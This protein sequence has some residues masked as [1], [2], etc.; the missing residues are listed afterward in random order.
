[1]VLELASAINIFVSYITCMDFDIFCMHNKHIPIYMYIWSLC[2]IHT[3]SNLICLCLPDMPLHINQYAFAVLTGT[4][5][6]NYTDY[7]T[8]VCIVNHNFN[9]FMCECM[10]IIICTVH[11]QLHRAHIQY[12][13]S[14]SE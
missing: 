13:P 10:Y 12:R 3:L 6:C 4:H 11:V 7:Y 2:N 8:C 9:D 1:M 5:A 14:K